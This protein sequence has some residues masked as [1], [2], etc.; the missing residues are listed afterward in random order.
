M[1]QAII[2]SKATVNT[3][4]LKTALTYRIR[5]RCKKIL[6]KLHLI[7]REAYKDNNSIISRETTALSI[8]TKRHDKM[9]IFDIVL[10][11]SYQIV[12]GSLQLEKHN[13]SI[14]QKTRSIMFEQCG[15][16]KVLRLQ[17]K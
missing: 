17:I 9:I 7:D 14:D 8:R 3:M 1:L 12:L 10:I 11:G 16:R 6:Y 2:D 4:L 5:T 15:C 13:L